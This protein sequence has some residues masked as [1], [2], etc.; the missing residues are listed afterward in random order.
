MLIP[1]SDR[2]SFTCNTRNKYSMY[3]HNINC[4]WHWDLIGHLFL[5]HLRHLKT[6]KTCLDD[7]K[8]I[9]SN[10]STVT[11][12]KTKPEIYH[13]DQSWLS[14]IWIS[15]P[16]VRKWVGAIEIHPSLTTAI[17]TIQWCQSRRNPSRKFFIYP[18]CW[19]RLLVVLL[20]PVILQALLWMYKQYLYSV[21]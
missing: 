4:V 7:R 11:I 13:Y 1:F 5:R 9:H 15:H 21:V 6:I 10:Y 16:C 19:V 12:G 20:I 18:I 2:T 17:G 8:N 3:D 14:N